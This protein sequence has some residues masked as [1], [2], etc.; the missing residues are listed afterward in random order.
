MSC[1]DEVKQTDVVCPEGDEDLDGSGQTT[2]ADEREVS[3]HVGDDAGVRRR[4]PRGGG[5]VHASGDVETERQHR[6]GAQRLMLLDMAMKSGLPIKEFAALVGVSH[7]TLYMWK[8]RFDEQGPGGVMDHPRKHKETESRLPEVIKRAILMIKERN[9]E[10]GCERISDMLGRGP[11]LKASPNAVLRVIR[12]AGLL[13]VSPPVP[14]HGEEPKRFERARPNQLWQSDI[15]TFLL[16]R[17]NRRVYL[18]AFLDDHSRYVVGYGIHASMGGALVIETLRAAI[19]AYGAPEEV[20]TDNGPQYQ[21]W[22]GKSRFSKELTKLGIKHILA[23]PKRPQ[24]VG[25]TERFWGTL[26]RECV[27]N[28]VFIDVEDA[29]KR[30]GHFID[31]YP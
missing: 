24:T 4:G 3:P 14:A 9:P 15:F 7:H 22:R 13:V 16:K 18:V 8:K 17:E 27:Q 1:F 19:A 26:W 11:G 20:L 10:Y 25:K 28:A 31:H 6:N 21:T 5:E 2:P 29:R 23:R 12:E 30:V